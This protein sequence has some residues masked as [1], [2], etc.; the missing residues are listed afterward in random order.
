MTSIP[1]DPKLL[2]QQTSGTHAEGSANTQAASAGVNSVQM[3]DTAAAPPP[4]GDNEANVQKLNKII[5]SCRT[6][7][8]TSHGDHGLHSRPMAT[9]GIDFESGKGEHIYFVTDKTCAK[10]KE[11]Q[12]NPEVALVFSNDSNHQ[13]ASVSATA[14][15][16]ED[17]AKTKELWNPMYNAWFPDGPEAGNVTLV[18]ATPTCGT[19]WE[20][21]A[22]TQ[23]HIMFS[24]IKA[25][26]TGTPID[27]KLS[28]DSKTVVFPGAGITAQ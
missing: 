4:A 14:K 18:C 26:V 22:M 12:A 9:A 8:L 6:C 23:L 17:P 24:A 13:W 11:I 7:M 27:Q 3:R 21:S 15:V 25:R 20:G 16:I 5:K 28:Q 2:D 19:F 10:V 1:V